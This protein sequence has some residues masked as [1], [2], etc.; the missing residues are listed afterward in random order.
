MGERRILVIGSQC[1]ALGNL[2]FLPKAAEE[3]YKVMIDPE[4]GACKPALQGHELFLNPSVTQTSEAIESAYLRAAKEGATLF[5]AYIGHGATLGRTF[6]LLPLD[7]KEHP[8][9]SKTAVPLVSL[10]LETHLNAGGKVD[11]LG[12]LLDTCYSGQ[13][14]FGAAQAW[15][16]DLEGALRFEVLT[17]AS[18]DRPAWNGCFSRTLVRLINEGVSE[19]PSEYLDGRDLRPLINCPG[20]EPQNPSYNPDTGLWLSRNAGR[21]LEP[22]AQTPVADEIRR[23]TQAYQ[24]TPALGEIVELSRKRRCVAVVGDAGSGKSALAAALAWPKVSE[25]MVPANFVHAIALIDEATTPHELART[26]THQLARCGIFPSARSVQ[27][28]NTCGRISAAWHI[29]ERAHWPAG[30]TRPAYKNPSGGRCTR[31]SRDRRAR[32]GHGSARR[33]LRTSVVKV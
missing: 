27:A 10:I 20:Q 29:G 28:G 33:A 19:N 16:A 13:A 4:R 15:V 14:G 2:P 12:M 30:K 25:G 23:L 7:A 9:T 22:W 11:G 26:L 8:L 21:I 17:S 18:A 3:L 32:T 6:Y 24:P 1:E 31:P 5:I